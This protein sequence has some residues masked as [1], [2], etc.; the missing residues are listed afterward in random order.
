VYLRLPGRTRL[1]FDAALGDHA[2]MKDLILFPCNGNAREALA[3]VDA[4]N[5][6][7]PTWNVLGYVDDRPS[8]AAARAGTLP[9]L[10]DRSCLCDFPEAALLAVPGRPDNFWRRLE[11]IDSLGVARE[12]FATLIHPAAQLGPDCH[13]GPNCLIHAGVVMTASVTVDGD[14]AILPNSVLSHDVHMERG[15]LMGAGVMV[16]GGVQLQQCAYVGAGSRLL[17]DTII[18]EQS[19]IGLGS[20]VIHSVPP[21]TVVA[22][23]P[24]RMLRCLLTDGDLA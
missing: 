17:Q 19:L 3:V 11:L 20:T 21:R 9:V 10:G 18:G 13:V 2:C 12:R 23:N 5:R 15:V 14:A 6:I 16:A 1:D 7:T 4:I 8:A 22:G 24:A